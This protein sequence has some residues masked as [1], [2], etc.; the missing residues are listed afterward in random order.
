MR[1][2]VSAAGA[3]PAI[4]PLAARLAAFLLDLLTGL[5]CC[6]V[7]AAVAWTW[8]LVASSGGSRQPADLAIY[9][10]IALGLLW[11]PVW[12]S[13][14]LLAW[15]RTGQTLGLAAMALRICDGR[16]LP[17]APLMALV[18]LL[19]LSVASVPLLL[20][21]LVVVG[22]IAAASQGTL[23]AP[24]GLFAALP[25]AVAAVDPAIGLLRRDR[26]ALHDLAA[27]T[28]VVQAC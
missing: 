18:R 5:G 24:V 21:P 26:R 22:L 17:P 6:L 20:A 19:I 2:T 25:I 4:A 11:I 13:Y 7:A 12:A 9:V 16:G 10:A 3:S 23:P 27:G 8:L 14:T 1:L 28:R 15:C